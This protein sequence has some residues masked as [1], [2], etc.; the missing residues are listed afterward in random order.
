MATG[1]TGDPSEISAA[2]KKFFTH[3]DTFR[4]H[5]G[6]LEGIK[7]EYAPAVQGATGNSIQTAMQSALDRGGKLHQTFMEIVDVL[8]S[9]GANFDSQDQ[10]NAAQVNKYNMN[11]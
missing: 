10:E 1:Y 8:N 3:A 11:F 4:N 6:I 9:A 2:A 5:L 7:M